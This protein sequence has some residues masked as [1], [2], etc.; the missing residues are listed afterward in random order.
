MALAAALAVGFSGAAFAAETSPLA[1]G[2]VQ[3]LV[4]RRAL[5]HLQQQLAQQQQLQ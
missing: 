2:T 3:V 5:V 1:A 4:Q